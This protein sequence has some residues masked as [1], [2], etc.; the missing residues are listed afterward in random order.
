MLRLLHI[1]L[2]LLT[3]AAYLPPLINP[4]SFWPIA[5]LGL[6]APIL[7]F[8]LLLFAL[9]WLWKRD[10]T[11]LLS[12]VTLLLGWDMISNA[13]AFNT[14]SEKATSEV[15]TVVSLNGR[16]FQRERGEE[17]PDFYQRG[18][19]YVASLDADLLLIQEFDLK[20][21]RA[22]PL[23]AAI[24]EEAGYSH[25]VYQPGGPLLVLS[26][27]PLSNSTINYFSNRANGFIVVDVESPQGT[28]R[29][30]NVHLQTNAV[31]RLAD[32]VTT[33]G[34]IR[35]PGT[36]QKVKTMFGRYG[37]SNKVR[38]EQASDILAEMERSPH[39]VIVGGDFNDVPTSY[40]YQQFRLHV[41][42]AHLEGSWGLG[43]TYKSF[44]PGLRI[45]YI[46]PDRSFEV[47]AFERLPCSFSD[48]HA[49]RAIISR[50]S[51]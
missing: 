4:A 19:K 43:T 15:I 12:L 42:D 45:D 27:Y 7:W 3:L 33:T 44:F 35:E 31:S 36:W 38:T 11:V 40:L 14:S 51:P 25:K 41:Q 47:H 20:R 26:R 1:F 6:V 5:T 10:K 21:N 2:V 30:F 39:P 37:R 22:D 17:K 13:F 48:H 9:Y 46:L 28:F 34:G 8:G 16:N 29:V 24:Q 50:G 23:L 49:I 18:A 32:E